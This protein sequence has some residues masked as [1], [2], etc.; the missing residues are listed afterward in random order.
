MSDIEL[1]LDHIYINLNIIV[2]L[3]VSDSVVYKNLK[4]SITQNGISIFTISFNVNLSFLQ[5][6]IASAQKSVFRNVDNFK[7]L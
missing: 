3:N 7:G 6:S 1:K 4:L 5:S 2:Q